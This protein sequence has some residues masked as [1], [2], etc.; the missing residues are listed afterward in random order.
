M[1]YHN[2]TKAEHTMESLAHHLNSGNLPGS[3]EPNGSKCN[4]VML[5]KVLILACFYMF[6]WQTYLITS[7]SF[8]MP[9]GFS[10]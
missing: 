9:T 5:P 6:D 8:W 4:P 7:I 1:L 2:L 3:H 10:T